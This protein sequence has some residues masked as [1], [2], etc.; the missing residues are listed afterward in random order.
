MREVNTAPTFSPFT[1]RAT[2]ENFVIVVAR[3]G[4]RLVPKGRLSRL[5]RRRWSPRIL[6][7]TE[8]VGLRHL[9]RLVRA[10]QACSLACPSFSQIRALRVHTHFSSVLELRAV[11]SLIHCR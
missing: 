10:V 4:P 6:E 3:R 8:D 5:R 11:S 1:S 2:N 9:R 7:E